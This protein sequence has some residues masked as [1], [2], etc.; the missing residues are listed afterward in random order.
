MGWL[1]ESAKDKYKDEPR[2][3]GFFKD[4]E[5][6][7]HKILESFIN[8]DDQL[9][10]MIQDWTNIKPYNPDADWG[11]PHE[12]LKKKFESGEYKPATKAE[13]YAEEPGSQN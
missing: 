1:K 12:S 11:I 10:Y 3:S 6:E 5:D 2:F 8:V 9:K 7:V 13:F 4:K